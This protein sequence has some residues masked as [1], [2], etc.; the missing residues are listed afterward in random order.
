[1]A[2]TL[3]SLVL[4][5]PEQARALS[6]CNR[7][8]WAAGLLL[9][10]LTGTTGCASKAAA[11]NL[12]SS[13][14]SSSAAATRAATADDDAVTALALQ[15]AS[16]ATVGLLV[17]AVPGARSARTLGTQRMGSGVVIGPDG[18]VLTIGYL[19][20]EAQ[21]I[22]LELDDGRH[23]PARPVGY[24]QATGFGLVQALAP[25]GITPVP[26]GSAE[27]VSQSEPLLIVSGGR[28]GQ[29]G[30][31]SQARVAHQREFSGTW[32]YHIRNALFTAPA[33]P[34]HS[35]AGLFNRKGELVGIGSLLVSDVAPDAAPGVMPDAAIDG[36]ATP[37]ETHTPGNM[38]VPVD[39]LKPVL[40][41]LRAS[42]N[43]RASQRAWLGLNCQER[44]GRLVVLR[45]TGDGPAELAG[46][47][48]GDVI[49]ALDDGE[50]HD[51]PTFYRR[52]WGEGPAEREVK[53]QITRPGEASR[54][55]LLRSV[56]RATTLLRADGI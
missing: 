32:E 29:A 38:F 47:R 8:A 23:I 10:L 43:T 41:E 30:L 14:S 26:L 36:S 49:T 18:L 3:Q 22:V 13:S 31:L 51:L 25:I 1:M 33:R 9:A 52:L 34:D 4:G 42:G 24:D 39:L 55:V 48:G 15:R 20:L 11:D 50:V 12:D 35:G 19:I 54:Q 2:R 16:D 27:R 17:R 46:V 40:A 21:D 45:V 28:A 56:D 37:R 6:C 5:G 44:N 7:L 53:L